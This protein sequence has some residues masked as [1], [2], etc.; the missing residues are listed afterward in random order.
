MSAL[1]IPNTFV[2]S[3]TAVASEVNANFSSIVN[4]STGVMQA[5]NAT[6]TVNPTLPASTVGLTAN[7]AVHK[8]FVDTRIAANTGMAIGNHTPT[9]ANLTTSNTVVATVTSGT[10]IP[11]NAVNGTLLLMAFADMELVGNAAAD[12]ATFAMNI[13]F[14]WDTAAASPVWISGGQTSG[15][16]QLTGASSYGGMSLTGFAYSV[17]VAAKIVG[18]RLSAVQRNAFPAVT[19]ASPRLTPDH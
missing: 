4:W 19:L 5:D 8:S 9:P 1:V 3:T 2:A 17:P 7:Q 12:G 18:V 16:V 11:L 14:C 6:F 10:A 15:L 13:E